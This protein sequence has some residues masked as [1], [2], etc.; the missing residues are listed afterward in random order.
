M[1]IIAV[2]LSC[3]FWSS[4]SR[5]IEDLKVFRGYLLLE[6]K[7]V[8][9]D[10]IRV[11]NFLSKK[12]NFEKI[13]R[14]VFL[15]SPG[16]YIGEA[17]KIGYLIRALELGTDAPSDPNTAAIGTAISPIGPADLMHPN[18]DYQCSS[19]CFLIYVAGVH[20][21]LGHAGRLGIHRPYQPK[22]TSGLP[23]QIDAQT[24]NVR[25]REEITKYLEKMDVPEKY[26]QLMYSVP[27]KDV[28]KI[29]QA[30]FDDD[31]KGYIPTLKKVVDSNCSRASSDFVGCAFR[32]NND[33]SRTAWQNEFSGK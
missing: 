27:S 10:Y 17:I 32:I 23:G 7:I 15:A 13:S 19:A 31:L 22:N 29:T 3:V 24:A 33:L 16:G 8:P 28:L 9:G 6:G 11:R 26:V 4:P 1:V 12:S 25:V 21:S 20:R 2:A 30:E 5:A 18:I 14:G